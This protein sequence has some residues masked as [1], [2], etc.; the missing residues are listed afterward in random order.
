[1]KDLNFAAGDSRSEVI[2]KQ[3][4]I[5][6]QPFGIGC[7]VARHDQVDVVAGSVN[8]LTATFANQPLGIAA[9]HARELTDEHHVLAGKSRFPMLNY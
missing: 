9:R 7:F 4:A 5:R 2:I 3:I 6:G 1:M 8:E